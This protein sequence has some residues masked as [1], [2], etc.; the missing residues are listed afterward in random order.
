MQIIVNLFVGVICFILGRLS[1]NF[2]GIS[3][4]SLD[5]SVNIV[6]LIS[7]LFTGIIAIFITLKLERY[8]TNKRVEKELYIAKISEIEKLLDDVDDLLKEKNPSYR[9]ISSINAFLR[10]KKQSIFNNIQ[11][12]KPI[13]KIYREYDTYLA[14]HIKI[15]KPLLTATS[16]DSGLIVNKDKCEYNNERIIEIQKELTSIKEKLFE[17]KVK[18]N[19]I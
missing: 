18:I 9:K 13:K 5:K 16:K 3:Y 7:I 6:E 2:P 8:V 15:L 11:N 1:V 12:F 4:F 19:S 10:I 17:F 14:D